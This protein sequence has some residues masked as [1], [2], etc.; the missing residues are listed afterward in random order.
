MEG[1]WRMSHASPEP[2]RQMRKCCAGA[3][4]KRLLE[5]READEK[6]PGDSSSHDHDVPGEDHRWFYQ[7]LGDCSQNLTM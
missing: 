4:G 7:D 1:Q 6:W 2:E 5:P 3:S